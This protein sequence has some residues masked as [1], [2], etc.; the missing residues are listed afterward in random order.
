[1]VYSMTGFGRVEAQVGQYQVIVELKSLNGKQ[2]DI[3][4]RVST[5][6]KPYEHEIRSAVGQQLQRGTIDV[7][8]T[9]KQ[10]GSSRPMGINVP[11]AIQYY[12]D[13]R[14]IATQL[15]ITEEQ[16][17]PTLMSLPDVVSA[18]QDALDED[19]WSAIR[20]VLDDAIVKL[21]Q[22]RQVEGG[23]LHTDLE[24]CMLQ[25][26][27]HLEQ[28]LIFEPNRLDRIRERI[29]TSLEDWVSS[30][31]ID[32]NRLEQELIYYIEKI[33][34]SEE[35][36]RLRQHC[37]FFREILGGTEVLKGKKLG[38]ILQEVGR[39]INTLGSKANDAE[40]QR[41]VVGMKDYLEKAKE[42][43]LNVL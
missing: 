25:I 22:H 3:N 14:K 10:D 32:Q 34:F 43:V 12:N 15:G 29:R 9:V 1:M 30:A 4:T 16:V 20:K 11:L 18:D 31:N 8:F 2:L 7:S 6:A 36:I 27:Q 19:G 39:E 13:M 41:L 33:D 17:L 38:F 24:H 5:L 26:E 28:I 37:A 21:Q 23:S 42:Q 40:I 35:K